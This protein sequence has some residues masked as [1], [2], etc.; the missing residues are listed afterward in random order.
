MSGGVVRREMVCVLEQVGVCAGV[1]E[2][3]NEYVV[4]N[5]VEKEPIVFDMAVAKSCEISGKGVVP[6]L[7]R[8][9]LSISKHGYDFVEL[10]DVLAASKHLL[11]AL[12]ELPQLYDFIFH[13][14][15]NSFSLAGSVQVG[16]FGS[17]ASF[18]DS[19]RSSTNCWCLLFRARVKGIP[20]TSRILARKQLKAVDMFM[21]MSSRMSSTSALSSASVRNVML[22]VIVCTPVVREDAS[23]I[24]YYAG[25]SN[26]SNSSIFALCRSR[27]HAV[28]GGG[29]GAV[30]FRVEELGVGEWVSGGVESGI[31]EAA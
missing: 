26:T 13:D 21:P 20:P 5:I 11:E 16:A 2:R 9:G 6:V 8:K 12:P 4:L 29:R 30:E 24:S 23:I 17:F 28:F 31:K 18:R 7:R 25:E 1:G 19:S 3:E 15:R 27:C 22:V 14:S 10:F